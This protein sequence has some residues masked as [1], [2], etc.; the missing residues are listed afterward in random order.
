MLEFTRVIL[1][2]GR[3]RAVRSTET[4]RIL[5]NLQTRKFRHSF[6]ISAPPLHWSATYCFR[7]NPSNAA[8]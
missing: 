5:I 8:R 7:W 2:L 4:F 6:S 1:C 3:V